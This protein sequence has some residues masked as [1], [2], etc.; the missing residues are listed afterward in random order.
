MEASAWEIAA[1]VIS[2][3]LAI[4]LEAAWIRAES[5]RRWVKSEERYWLKRDFIQSAR[6]SE[7]EHRR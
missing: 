2:I 7:L 3:L 5:Y 1:W 6:I 4:A